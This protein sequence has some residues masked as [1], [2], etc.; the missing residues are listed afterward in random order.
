V[1]IG[2]V[3]PAFNAAETI[4][5]ALNSLLTQSWQD[6]VIVVV[7]DGSTDAT[8]AIVHSYRDPRIRLVRQANA[9]VSAARN[10]GIAAIEAD[11]LLFLDADDW[12]APHALAALKAG[13]EAAPQAV[14]AVGPC[15]RV[16]ATGHAGETYRPNLSG[17][18]LERL[19]TTSLFAN[20]GHLLIRRAAVDAA[21][22]FRTDLVYGEDWEY[23]V[24]LALLGPF[25]AARADYPICFIRERAS[26]AYSRMASDPASYKP[27]MDA[28]QANPALPGLIPA[29]RRAK[30]WKFAHAECLWSVGRE[31]IRHGR[32][33]A[34]HATLRRSISERLSFRRLLILAATAHIRWIPIDWRGPFTPYKAPRRARTVKRP[35][36]MTVRWRVAAR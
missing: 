19:L 15:A 5:E 30:L 2:I 4:A 21:G 26:G 35:S 27:C 13:L 8:A 11:A 20:G 10:A 22:P 36:E 9:G 7:D 32:F 18:V 29:K 24:R 3:T 17:N 23:W 14:A 16:R 33:E 25:V 6:W 28:I 31:L 12:L 34:G 1:R